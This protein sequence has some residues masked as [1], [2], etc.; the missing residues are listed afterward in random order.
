MTVIMTAPRTEKS[1]C[2]C[3]ATYEEKIRRWKSLGWLVI[4]FAL[5]VVVVWIFTEDIVIGI[6]IALASN[7]VKALMYYVYE[8]LWAYRIKKATVVLSTAT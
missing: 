5:S 3:G 7:I 8:R 4:S 6:Y 2:C 1:R